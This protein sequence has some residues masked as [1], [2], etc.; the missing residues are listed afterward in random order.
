MLA[1]RPFCNSDVPRLAM[2]WVIHHAAFRSAPAVTATIWEQAIASRH[3]FLPERLLVATWDN[4]PVAWCHWF[5]DPR[6]TACLTAF[7]FDTS[8][9]GEMAAVQLLAATQQRVVTAGM[10][11]LVAGINPESRWGYQG[12]DPVGQGIGIDVADDR[13]NLLLEEAGFE[14][15]QRIDKWEVNTSDFRPPVNREALQLRR[16][17][18]IEQTAVTKMSPQESAAMFHLDIRRYLLI[19]PGGGVPLATSDLWLSDPDVH[20]MTTH[21]AILGDIEGLAEDLP[22]R[23]PAIRYL[24]ASLVPML[25]SRHVLTLHRSVPSDNHDEA[26]RM[27]ALKFRR[28]AVGRLLRKQF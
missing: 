1:I 13:T 12:L 9:Q 14:E 25:A 23:E 17:T 18:R 15:L 6:R 2:L 26:S 3:F 19:A 5:P 22:A 20:V 10:T 21:Q 4:L 8:T 27:A 7:C 24:I 28:T 16:G 11:T